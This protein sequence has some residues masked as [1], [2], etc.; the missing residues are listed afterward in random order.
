VDDISV[1]LNEFAQITNQACIVSDQSTIAF[2]ATEKV[3]VEFVDCGPGSITLNTSK[4]DVNCKGETTGI[5]TATPV[6]GTTPYSYIWSNGDVTQT[7]TNLASGTYTVTVSD[8]NQCEAETIVNITEPSNVLTFSLSYFNIEC[9]GAS[10]GSINV[11]PNGGMSPYTFDWDFDGTGDFDDPE[12]LVN[13]PAGPYSITVMDAN[14]CTK[15][16]SVVLSEGTEEYSIANRN[17]L[18]GT[19]LNTA[20]F[21]TD[22]IIESDQIIQGTQGINVDYDSGTQILL[23]PGFE[24]KLTNVFHA[25]IDGCGGSN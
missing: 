19:Q 25:F 1:T 8:A 14:A 23:K 10:T 3:T 18:T 20:D 17:M 5:A 13:I 6:G 9:F 4:T 15:S 16:I 7:I 22:G 11:T 21:E 24:V 12:D 2:C